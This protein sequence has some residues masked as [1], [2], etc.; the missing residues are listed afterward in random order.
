MK[1]SKLSYKLIC[2]SVLE[3]LIELPFFVVPFVKK[4]AAI[5]V[6]F[7]N[8]I[9]IFNIQLKKTIFFI[10]LW[11]CQYFSLDHMK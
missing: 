8:Y 2:S 10:N 11:I 4:I 5:H 3:G 9:F 1:I 6:S 7:L